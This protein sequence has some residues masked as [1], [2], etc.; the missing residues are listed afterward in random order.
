MFKHCCSD[1]RE[2][3]KL[4][5]AFAIVQT[6]A[7]PTVSLNGILRTDE[8][9]IFERLTVRPSQPGKTSEQIKRN[10]PPDDL[11]RDVIEV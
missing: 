8:T 10:V 5:R 4:Y 7:Y 11:E 9:E 6:Y 1:S 3:Q 2:Q